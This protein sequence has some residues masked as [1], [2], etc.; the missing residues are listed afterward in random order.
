MYGVYFWV[1]LFNQNQ[2]E[3]ESLVDSM[4]PTFYFKNHQYR[5]LFIGKPSK[6]KVINPIYEEVK[7]FPDE[8]Y[9]WPGYEIEEG[10]SM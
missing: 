9:S 5:G 7:D 10:S 8:T 1:N 6:T 3:I 2:S 4:F